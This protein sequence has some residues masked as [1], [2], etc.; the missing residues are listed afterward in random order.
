MTGSYQRLANHYRPLVPSY[1]DDWNL[2]MGV[3]PVPP[4]A[5][6]APSGV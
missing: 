4:D 1:Q 6:K 5:A 2:M 3:A